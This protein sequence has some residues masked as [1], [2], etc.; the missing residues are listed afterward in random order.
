MPWQEA[1]VTAAPVQSGVA[2][3]PVTP[4]KAKFPWQ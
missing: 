4:L 3:K 1:Q 2:F